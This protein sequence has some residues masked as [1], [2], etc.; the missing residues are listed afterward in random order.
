MKKYLRDQRGNE[1]KGPKAVSY[2]PLGR[3]HRTFII[4]ESNPNHI[5][6]SQGGRKLLFRRL[7]KLAHH[8]CKA[9][10]RILQFRLG[11]FEI[12]D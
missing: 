2:D 8:H 10:I 11:F 12:L 7:R 6:L 4:N 3:F 5:H 1:L 9:I